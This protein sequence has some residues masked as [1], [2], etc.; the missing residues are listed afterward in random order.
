MRR[1]VIEGSDERHPQ[2]RAAGTRRDECED[3]ARAGKDCSALFGEETGTKIPDGERSGLRARSIV[4]VVRLAA[5]FVGGEDKQV[6]CATTCM[7]SVGWRRS[8]I[9]GLVWIDLGFVIAPD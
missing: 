3:F 5:G 2:S 1:E 4:D 6:S 8:V 7:D 9:G